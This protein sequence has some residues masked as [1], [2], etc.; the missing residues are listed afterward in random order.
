M[1]TTADKDGGALIITDKRGMDW[2]GLHTA[3]VHTN[4]TSM[5]KL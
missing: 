1:K 4:K 2:E 5:E 3:L